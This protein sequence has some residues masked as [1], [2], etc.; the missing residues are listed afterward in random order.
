[1]SADCFTQVIQTL[2]M[3][4]GESLSW[5]VV[6]AS[7][8]FQR[9][10]NGSNTSAAQGTVYE[11]LNP[12]TPGPASAVDTEDEEGRTS[13]DALDP[14]NII[15][16]PLAAPDLKAG[17]KERI[18]MTGWKL[19]LLALPACCDI[20]GTTLMNVGLLFVAASIYQMTRGA[21]VLFVGL[22]SVIFLKRHL[23]GWKWASLFIVVLG[24]ALVGLAGV[25][26]NKEVP[27]DP[28]HGDGHVKAELMG[29][30]L[31]MVKR[32]AEEVV[33][34]AQEHTAVETFVGILLIAGAQIFTATQF[35]LE[36]SI[37]EKYELE[38]IKV[39]GWEGF[40]GMVVTLIL[41]G[42]LHGAVGMTKAGKGGYFDAREGFNQVFHHRAIAVS[43]GL[44]M[45]SIGYES[46]SFELLDNLLTSTQRLQFLRSFGHE[47]D[48]RHISQ[49]NRYMPD[50]IHLDSQFGP[51]MGII[52]VATSCWICSACLWYRS[53]QRH[54]QAANL[55]LCA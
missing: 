37:M 43:S 11:P 6:L 9:L 19:L 15:A 12:D 10:R 55:Q 51:R 48:Q 13:E 44:I 47:T 20:A 8:I 42:V 34:M 40:F 29:R 28:G 30:A 33:A 21:L 24:V 38:P 26:G 46:F 31:A 36:E 16:K 7:F 25:F 32:G 35:V 49:H 54:H 52:Q 50:V 45:I 17:D 5:L 14:T 39:V 53:I 23:G 41:M 27:V 4:I 1:M 3:F 2:Q 18:P 22:F